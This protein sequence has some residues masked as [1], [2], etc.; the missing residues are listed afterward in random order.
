MDPLPF[1]HGTPSLPCVPS[2]RVVDYEQ[3]GRPSDPS[4]R[5]FQRQLTAERERGAT[6]AQAAGRRGC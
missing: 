1:H 3:L 6:R 2:F 4:A 5:H